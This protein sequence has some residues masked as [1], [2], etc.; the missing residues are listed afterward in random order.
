MKILVTGAAGFIGFFLT[1]KLAEFGYDV[2][3]IDN[4]NDYYDVNL[5]N[6][7]LEQNKILNNYKFI[8]LDIKEKEGLFELFDKEQF[9]CVCNLA[10]QAGVRY[11]LENPYTYIDNNIFGFLNILEACKQYCIKH[12][13]YASSSSV[14]GMN[15]NTSFSTEDKTDKPISLYALT[16]NS[17]EQMAYMYSHL[18]NIPTTGLRFFTVYGPW[19]RPDMAYY[20]FAKKIMNNEPIDVYNNGEMYRDYTYIDDIIDGVLAVIEKGQTGDN[21]QCINREAAI[22]VGGS[23]PYS[24]HDFNNLD[25]GHKPLSNIYNL[26]NSNPV[27]LKDFIVILENCL[28]KK[29]QINYLPIQPGDVISTCADI[30]KTRKDLDWQPKIKIEKGLTEFT[31]W[32]KEY[33]K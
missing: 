24:N 22:P 26:G 16:K 32:F 3:G 12:L 1:R 5:K 27:K 33:N 29:A 21:Y 15:E 18:Y 7:R 2:T 14:Y 4:L 10:A 20:K 28:R 8:K 6:D 13:V 30:E 25:S 31:N 11:S 9:D 17:N 19:G 23:L